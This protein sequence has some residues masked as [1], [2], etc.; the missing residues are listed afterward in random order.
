MGAA[1]QAISDKPPPPFPNGNAAE[2][3]TA[4]IFFCNGIPRVN[5]TEHLSTRAAEQ[6]DATSVSGCFR[7]GQR[8]VVSLCSNNWPEGR[9]G[10]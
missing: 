4:G 2:D 6:Q 7:T 5:V 10:K 3:Q 8:R 9:L 1:Q